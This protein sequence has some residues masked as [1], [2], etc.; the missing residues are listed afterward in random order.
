GLPEITLGFIPGLGG[1]QR[2]GRLV[3]TSRALSL[4]LTGDTITASEAKAM[5]LV[6]DV[7]PSAEL[8][9]V[10]LR[11]ARRVARRPKAVIAAAIETVMI[12]GRLSLEEGLELEARAFGRLCDPAGRRHEEEGKR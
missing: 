10:V 2:L 3:G 1:T 5:G 8:M 12:G 4:I 6:D 11:Y 7:V 9:P